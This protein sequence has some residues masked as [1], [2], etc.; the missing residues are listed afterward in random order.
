MANPPV[1]LAREPS[2]RP[3]TAPPPPPR[4]R[5]TRRRPRRRPVSPREHTPR[6]PTRHRRA[7]QRRTL[8]FRG[9]LLSSPLLAPSTGQRVKMLPSRTATPAANALPCGHARVPIRRIHWHSL[10]ASVKPTR[11]DQT[12]SRSRRVLG[13][14]GRLLT[15]S[16]PASSTGQ[17]KK[18]LPSRTVTPAAHAPS[19]LHA[20]APR[21]RIHVQVIIHV[22]D[23]W[24]G[25]PRDSRPSG[26]C[27][28]KRPGRPHTRR[29]DPSI[30]TIILGARLDT[31]CG[32]NVKK[33]QNK[34]CW[35]PSNPVLPTEFGLAPT[36]L[37]KEYSCNTDG[38]GPIG[39]LATE[40]NRLQALSHQYQ[41][42]SISTIRHALVIAD[43]DADSP[44]T[45]SDRAKKLAK[46][47]L[48]KHLHKADKVFRLFV[49]HGYHPD[50]KI[51]LSL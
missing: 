37:G 7:R 14:R 43:T 21:R 25:S 1:A 46:R 30:M 51:N 49:S 16:L 38:D 5:A 11:P 42:A 28:S 34:S 48:L 17:Q 31:H 13:F 36:H 39:S 18:V 8:G 44:G 9:R 27:I 32:P 29:A 35:R 40:Y 15:S 33:Q 45:I 50:D 4:T 19:P 20:I 10:R 23:T 26:Y 41:S 12:P 6:S 2:P 3:P 22:G 24:P 47:C